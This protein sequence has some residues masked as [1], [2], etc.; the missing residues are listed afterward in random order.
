[1]LNGRQKFNH[2]P[3]LK[4]LVRHYRRLLTCTFLPAGMGLL[5][6]PVYGNGAETS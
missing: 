1:M 3:N 5:R 6:D 4:D 2:V